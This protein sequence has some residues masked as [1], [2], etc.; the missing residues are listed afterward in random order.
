MR[1]HLFVTLLCFSLLLTVVS[2]QEPPTPEQLQ[3]QIAAELHRLQS[4]RE[5]LMQE[6]NALASYHPLWAGQG[7][8]DMLSFM[9]APP[10][11]TSYNGT[12]ADVLLGL[13][14]EQMQQLAFTYDLNARIEWSRQKV[15]D[16]PEYARA[17][18]AARAAT[19]IPDDYLFEHA[20]E[21]Q[22]NA[23]REATVAEIKMLSP[24]MHEE[25]INILT[26]EQLLQV[27]KWEMQMMSEKGLPCPAMFEILDLT[28]DQKKEMNEIAVEMKVEFDSLVREAVAVKFERESA[29]YKLLE[30][31][32]FVSRQEFN[33]QLGEVWR[34]SVDGIE[35]H[36]SRSL[37]GKGIELLTLL[38]NRLMNVLTDEQLDKMQQ[39]IDETPEYLKRY[40]AAR[41]AERETQRQ[42]PGYVPGPDSWRPGMPVPER[43]RQ[44]R[45]PGRFPQPAN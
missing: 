6:A 44:E 3:Q 4:P 37:E 20:T 9:L 43:F 24:V 25:I 7:T 26:P 5:Q 38:Q 42:A 30:G 15:Q 27:R 36:K 32:T 17:V 45:R 12:N 35:I 13:T 18:P 8:V 11:R 41:K 23:F 14:E 19:N 2:A 31:K 1:V 22:K 28:D 33:E 39:I 16:M 34:K 21:E 29:D 10:R 40:L